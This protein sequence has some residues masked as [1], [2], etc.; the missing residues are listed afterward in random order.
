MP[1][2]IDGKLYSHRVKHAEGVRKAVLH[3]PVHPCPLHRQESRVFFRLRGISCI[4]N[5]SLKVE[6]IW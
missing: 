5:I 2:G 6:I 3:Q 1:L 4:R